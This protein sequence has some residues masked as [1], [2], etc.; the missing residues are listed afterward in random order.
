MKSTTHPLRRTEIIVA[1]ETI[2]AYFEILWNKCTPGAECRIYQRW[3][4]V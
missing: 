2:Y 4:L 1:Y 3:R